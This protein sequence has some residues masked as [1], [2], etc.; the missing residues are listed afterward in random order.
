MVSIDKTPASHFIIA[1][2]RH[3][4]IP[5]QAKRSGVPERGGFCRLHWKIFIDLQILTCH[6]N[7]ELSGLF[8][9][10]LGDSDYDRQTSF[11]SFVPFIVFQ[12][13]RKS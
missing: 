5:A 7:N 12:F 4:V 1:P 6:N 3:G 9:V 11:V 13:F 2:S 8:K 10:L